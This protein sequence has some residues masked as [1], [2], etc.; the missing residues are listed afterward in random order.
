MTSCDS[1]GTM[2]GAYFVSKRDLLEWL[3]H[4]FELNIAKIE[5]CGNGII[6]KIII[7][8]KNMYTQ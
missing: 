7:T 8:H 5:D 1:I 3:R 6:I 4:D 2:D